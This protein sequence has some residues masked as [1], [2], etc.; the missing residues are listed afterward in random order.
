MYWLKW[1]SS[2]IR[3]I[4]SLFIWVF[5]WLKLIVLF[6]APLLFLLH[7]QGKEECALFILKKLPDAA[8]VNATNAALQTW[9]C[10]VKYLESIYLN[11]VSLSHI[12]SRVHFFQSPPPC[13]SQWAKADG[14]GAVVSRSQR[15][16][17]GWERCV[18]LNLTPQCMLHTAACS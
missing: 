12:D 16:A 3:T 5:Q 6:P 9:V 14:A 17:L 4:G 13:S 15:A 11:T 1:L 2:F 7:S 10:F 8:L 18:S